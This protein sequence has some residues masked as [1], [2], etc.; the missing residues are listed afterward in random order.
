MA[1]TTGEALV[2]RPDRRRARV[3]LVLM[4]LGSVLA[5]ALL[6]RNAAVDDPS[7]LAWNVVYLTGWGA[8]LLYQVYVSVRS[9]RA[10]AL[11]EI[12]PD[13]L[14][15]N[16]LG[17]GWVTLPWSAVGR[18]EQRGLMRGRVRV[19]LARGVTTSTPGVELPDATSLDRARQRGFTID[20]V[21]SN[22]RSTEVVEAAERF[23]RGTV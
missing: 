11:M 10:D 16:D 9:L 5:L 13:A 18:V 1:V 2:V 19:W 3:S 6:V 4:G 17:R 23:R 8:F 22:L 21:T 15:I 7:D 20:T 14:R 12:G